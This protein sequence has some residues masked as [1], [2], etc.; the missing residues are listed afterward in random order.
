MSPA[1]AEA[2]VTGAVTFREIPLSEL[3]EFRQN[4][5]KRFDALSLQELA[6]SIAQVGILEPLIV[7][8]HPDRMDG[9]E[10]IAGARRLRAARL[11]GLETVPCLVRTLSDAEALEVAVTEN[12]QRQDVH[13]LDEADGYHALMESDGAYSVEAVAARF[14]KSTSYVYQ[15]LKLRG[16]TPEAREAFETD[17]ITAAHAVRLARLSAADQARALDECFYGL[18]GGA[19]GFREV[20]PVSRLDE[21]IAAHTKVDVADRETVQHYLP[22]LHE[23]LEHARLDGEDDPT[24]TLL[25]LSE[26]S[27]PGHFLGDK[28]HG[29]IGHGRWKELKGATCKHAK[30]GVV[31]HGGPLRVLWVCATKGCPKHWPIEKKAA[32]GTA[33]TE[34][35]PKYDYEAEEG[36]RRAERER[37]NALRPH[38]LTAIAKTYA[39]AKWTDA[40]MRQAVES[41]SGNEEIESVVLAAGYRLG[42][43]HAGPV[44]AFLFSFE[45]LWNLEQLRTLAK[46]HKVDLKAIEKEV[47]ANAK[48]DA[49]AKAAVEPKPSS[50]KGGRK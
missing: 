28:D 22:E 24:A 40:L 23:Q 41:L 4:P 19:V 20:K 45:H 49:D 21:W 33:K 43:E 12:L 25:Q 10:L 18:L 38:V 26:S 5:R 17:E 9:Y 16:L 6:N 3:V 36:K 13:P 8:P 30:R 50:K 29:L 48:A 7:R 37:F 44:F 15:R 42:I 47:A 11:A 32:K 31:V 39:E 35:A 34:R 46:Q 27:M 1:V 14:G 2:P